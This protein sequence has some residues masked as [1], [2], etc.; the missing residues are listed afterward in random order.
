LAG[1]ARAGRVYPPGHPAAREPMNSPDAPTA[2]GPPA[3]PD[4]ELVRRARSGDFSA[5]EELVGRF[6]GRVYGLARRIVGEPHDAEDVTQQTFLSLIEH[7][8]DFRG[9]SAVAAWVLRIAAN[10]ALKLLRKRR[11]L[12]TVRLAEPGRE[13]EGYADVPHPEFIAPWRDDP[14]V[15]AS[16]RE[17]RELVD[18][19]LAELDEKYRVVFVLRDVEGLSVA[20]TAEALGLTE[21]AVKVRLLRARLALRERLTRELGDEGARLVP[22]HTHGRPH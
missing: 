9:E 2:H 16:R 14:A 7:L 8:R 18:R 4:L 1:A 20:E 15:I 3:D 21:S 12:P 10:H 19:A 11:G 13:D 5:F 22:D 6:Q 17:V